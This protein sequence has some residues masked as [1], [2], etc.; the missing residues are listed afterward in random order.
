LFHRDVTITAQHIGE[1]SPSE[2]HCGF[3]VEIFL[4]RYGKKMCLC[5]SLGHGLG[6][7]VSLDCYEHSMAQKN[8]LWGRWWS[9]C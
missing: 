7:W 4:N 6:H 5:F 2:A 8:A 3:V 9:L 1:Q